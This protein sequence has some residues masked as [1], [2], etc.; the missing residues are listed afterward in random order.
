MNDSNGIA[1]ISVDDARCTR[2][3]AC[4]RDC[5]AHILALPKSGEAAKTIAG[6][7]ARC[8]KCRHC[9]AICP[10]GALSWRDE[11]PEDCAS[12]EPLPAPELVE[13][14][15]RNR[16]SVR[17]YRRENVA[18][19]ILR[20]L[21]EATRYSPTGCND[22]GLFFAYSDNVATTDAFRA[23]TAEYM[24]RRFA[25]K[26]LPVSIQRFATFVP[27]IRAGV[28]VFFRTAPHFVAIACAPEARDAHIDPYIAA[29]QFELLANSFGLGTCWAGMP[30]DLFRAAPELSKALNIPD[31][32]EIK[33]VL[34]FGTPDVKYARA[35]KQEPY[36]FATADSAKLS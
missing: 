22:R 14:L 30:T 6:G 35:P 9:L 28:D 34:L 23:K 25:D 16:R 7:E 36:P 11:K 1:K 20:R 3:G 29:A 13:N 19:D 8:F 27:Q 18:P 33:I 26:T 17:S 12:L 2:C 24:I 5:L 10:T 4:V 21:R 32:F 15:L 31:A